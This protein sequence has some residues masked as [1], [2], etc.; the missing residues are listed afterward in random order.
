M[1]GGCSVCKLSRPDSSQHGTGSEFSTNLAMMFH[2]GTTTTVPKFP[3]KLSDVAHVRSVWSVAPT[4]KAYSHLSAC[5]MPASG[6]FGQV[7]AHGP[8]GASHSCGSTQTPVRQERLP[9][10]HSVSVCTCRAGSWFSAV[11]MRHG[12][13]LASVVVCSVS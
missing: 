7:H 9:G 3:E 8:E 12:K 13:E 11:G 6:F 10:E 5:D 4:S 1:R 2:V